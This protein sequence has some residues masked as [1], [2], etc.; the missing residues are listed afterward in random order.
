MKDMENRMMKMKGYIVIALMILLIGAYAGYKALSK[1]E[2]IAKYEGTIIS[3]TTTDGITSMLVDGKFVDTDQPPAN[4]T[5]TMY[6]LNKDAKITADGKSIEASQLAIGNYVHLEGGN[7]FLTSYPAQGGADKVILLSTESPDILIN[8][9]VLEVREASGDNVLSFLVEGSVTG[10]PG[11]SQVW[12]SVPDSSYYPMGTRD[13]NVVLIPGDIIQVLID[14][15]MAE[16]YPMQAKS[17]SVIITTF[18]Q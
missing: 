17:S 11:D 6:T 9:T 7:M 2:D 18:A 12:V 1:D 16:S 5:V 8:G 10:Y 14:G 3:I 4:R 13:G 15:A